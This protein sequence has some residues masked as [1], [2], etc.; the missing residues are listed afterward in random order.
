VKKNRA[1]L[2]DFHNGPLEAFNELLE[3]MP[4]PEPVEEEEEEEEKE[5]E[6]EAAVEEGTARSHGGE[7]GAEDNLGED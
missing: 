6:E 3:R 4:P 2:T 5:K 1:R 7:A